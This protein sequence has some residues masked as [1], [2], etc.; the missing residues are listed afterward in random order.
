[1]E[2]QFDMTKSDQEPRNIFMKSQQKG[3]NVLILDDNI[4]TIRML[5]KLLNR[6][7]F[8]VDYSTNGQD[9]IEKFSKSKSEGKEYSF[10]ILDIVIPNGMSGDTALQ[11]ILKIDP[12]VKAIVSSGYSNNP[13]MSN[14][15]DYGFVGVLPKPYTIKDLKETIKYVL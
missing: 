3:R 10:L 12:N 5:T 2:N 11:E 13:I 4:S 14:Y 8:N 9:L 6:M 7:G 1:M 15:N